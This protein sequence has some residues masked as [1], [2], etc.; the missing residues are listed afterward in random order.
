M[1]CLYV[2]REYPADTWGNDVASTLR[3]RCIDDMCPLGNIYCLSVCIKYNMMKYAETFK[4]RH[5]AFNTYFVKLYKFWGKKIDHSIA[6]IN[7]IEHCRLPL[8]HFFFL[9]A[10]VVSYVGLFCHYLSLSLL[11]WW[12]GNPS[13]TRRIYNVVSTSMQRHDVALTLSRRCKRHDIASALR[14][15]V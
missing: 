2:L 1:S 13:G 4:G 7:E 5:T 3:R 12:L 9:C 14:D 11:F 15:V 10:S 8:L 6:N